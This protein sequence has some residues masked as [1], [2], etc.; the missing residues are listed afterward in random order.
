METEKTCKCGYKIDDYHVERKSFYTK[1]GWFL[2]GIGMSAKPI[3]VIFQCQE[4]GMIFQEIT[5][6][7]ELKKFIGR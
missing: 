5:D 7:S 6:E 4:C 2:Y 3:R 1:F